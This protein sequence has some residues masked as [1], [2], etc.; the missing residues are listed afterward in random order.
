MHSGRGDSHPTV[1]ADV[2]RCLFFIGFLVVGF[3]FLMSLA[4]AVV[5][6]TY[7]R[8][9]TKHAKQQRKVRS[10]S[11]RAAFGIL[12]STGTHI[13]HRARQLEAECLGEEA[14]VNSGQAGWISCVCVA[15]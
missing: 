7:N 6:S 5:Y 9:Q 11:L 12:E 15:P 14:Q 1:A 2:R 8:R 13:A 4:M 10:K 3:F